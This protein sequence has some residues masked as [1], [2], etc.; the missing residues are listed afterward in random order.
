VPPL[1]PAAGVPGGSEYHPVAEEELKQLP[2]IDNDSCGTA[3]KQ[4]W[5]ESEANA[6]GLS[7]DVVLR[8]ELDERGKV[9]SVK[10]VKGISKEV[11]AMA[12][13]FI[14][15]DPRCRAKPAIGKDGKPAA[16]VIERY[17][18]RFERE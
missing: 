9:R 13:G 1:P 10:V 12:L 18:V 15:F 5:T 16:F 3:M 14:R 17:T 11:D 2:E 6:N 7:G 8:I 4:K